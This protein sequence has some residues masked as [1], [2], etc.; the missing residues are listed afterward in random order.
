MQTAKMIPAEEFCFH[1]HIELSFISLLHDSGLIEIT[2]VDEKIFIYSIQPE[3]LERL[4]RLH[5]ELVINLKGVA[6]VSHLLQRLH[7]MQRQILSLSNRLRN[8]EDDHTSLA[9]IS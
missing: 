6:I 4:V 9:A 8:Y 7:D 3:V 1:H 5:A 2:V